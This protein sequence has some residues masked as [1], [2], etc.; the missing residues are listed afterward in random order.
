MRKTHLLCLL[1]HNH[2]S[3]RLIALRLYCSAAHEQSRA[4]QILS[5]GG[6][7]ALN[8]KCFRQQ[9][10]VLCLCDVLAVV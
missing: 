3:L 4:G 2:I 10:L 6:A 7:I 5:P 9:C 1:V 8:V